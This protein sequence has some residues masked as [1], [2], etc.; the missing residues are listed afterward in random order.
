[1]KNEIN[2]EAVFVHSY[3]YV[4]ESVITVKTT[5]GVSYALY[6]SYK[7]SNLFCKLQE[8]QS[9]TFS[10]YMTLTSY[11]INILPLE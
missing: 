6:S 11:L 5:K 7:P 1:M 9:N 8:S 10:E 2:T 4:I 3:L